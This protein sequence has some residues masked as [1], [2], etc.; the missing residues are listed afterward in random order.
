MIMIAKIDDYDEVN[1]GNGSNDD[2]GSPKLVSF[3]HTHTFV[4]VP[5]VK[6]LRSRQVYEEASDDDGPG[7]RGG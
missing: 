1:D 5:E 7:P 3:H 4:D 2:D 6:T